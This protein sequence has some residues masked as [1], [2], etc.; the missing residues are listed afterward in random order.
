MVYQL[1]PLQVVQNIQLNLVRLNAYSNL[2]G[3]QPR[4]K[5]DKARRM[6]RVINRILI[7]D[8]EL[9]RSLIHHLRE[10]IIYVGCC[11]NWK[12]DL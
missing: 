11:D 1:H 10:V 5:K 6:G 2:V 8:I 7:Y 3:K 9:I 12:V 4:G